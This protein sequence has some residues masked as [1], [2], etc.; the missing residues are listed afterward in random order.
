MP[1][2]VPPSS[3]DTL[4]CRSYRDPHSPSLTIDVSV[5]LEDMWQILATS[6]NKRG[7]QLGISEFD[8]SLIATGDLSR[9]LGGHSGALG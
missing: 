1:S 4:T 5:Y 8:G 2:S 3:K 6:G 7:C 9:M